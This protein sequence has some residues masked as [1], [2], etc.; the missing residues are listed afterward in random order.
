MNLTIL[1]VYEPTSFTLSA[2]AESIAGRSIP[3]GTYVL[4]PGV[5][6]LDGT[7]TPTPTLV[8]TDFDA[9]SLGGSKGPWPDP[10]LRALNELSVTRSNLEAFLMGAGEI[11]AAI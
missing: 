5:Y 7:A 9:V 1:Y 4:D 8:P 2:P 3:A 11:Q 10:P 6:R